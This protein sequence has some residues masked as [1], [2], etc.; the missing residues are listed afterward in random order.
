MLKGYG[1]KLISLLLLLGLA[2]SVAAQQPPQSLQSAS[3]V[4]SSSSSTP[5][6]PAA[7]TSNPDKVVAS[8]HSPTKATL[9]SLLPGAGQ[10]YNHQA[11]KIP[12]IYGILGGLGYFVYD[13]YGKMVS[14]REEYLLR[15]NEGTKQ[16][17]GYENYPDASIYNLY[18][19]YNQRFQLFVILT[20]V[21]YGLNLVDAYVFGH[22]FD[23]QIN[24]D[25]SLNL[26]PEMSPQ[27]LPLSGPSLAPSLSLTLSF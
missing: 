14:F 18:Q 19:S 1:L 24:D 13:N 2:C 10:V 27:W 12:I 8:Q 3:P 22:L 9:L 21:A 6:N 26:S 4:A 25:L 11:W 16:L 17:R 20:A 5:D 15:V 7:S 23:F